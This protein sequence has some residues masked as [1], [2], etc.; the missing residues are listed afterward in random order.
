MAYKRKEYLYNSQLTADENLLLD[1]L[2]KLRLSHMAEALEKQFFNPN[3]N[4]DDFMT[5]VSDLINYEWDQ[6]QTKKFNRLLKK[7]WSSVKI[8]DS[9]FLNNS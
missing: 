6:R 4:L 3:S 9:K 8:S 1:R 2:F 5:R 7:A